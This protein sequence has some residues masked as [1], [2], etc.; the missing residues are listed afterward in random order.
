MADPYT[1]RFGGWL[2][3]LQNNGVEVPPQDNDIELPAADCLNVYW[4]DS[5]YRCLPS[6][7]SI[8]PSL[9]TPIL[10]CFTWYD[11]TQGKEVLFATTANGLWTLVDG[12]WSSVSIETQEGVTGF[13][14]S[15]RL[16]SVKGLATS[17]SPASE[18]ASGSTTSHVFSAL[19]ARIGSGTATSYTWSFS[20]HAG[21]GT[22]SIASGQGTANA[23]PQVTGSTSGST[24]TATCLCTIVANGVSYG[25]SSSLSY[26]QNT[27][28]PLLHAYTSGSGTETVP[29]GYTNVVI[30]IKGGGAGT[31]TPDATDT[32][33]DGGG[34][35][36]YC[37]TS[38]AVTPGGTFNYQVGVAGGTN[39]HGNGVGGSASTVT[40]GSI[41]LTT[42]T[43]N[44]GQGAGA[45][46]VGGTATGGNQANVTGHNGVNGG[47]G[48]TSGSAGLHFDTGNAYGRGA[49]YN[50][51]DETGGFVSFYYTA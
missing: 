51:N 40:S 31:S 5:S 23:V 10:D 14:I 7:A 22:W 47:V 18:S 20:A 35:A 2:P 1:I 25:V 42:M 19:S 44:G 28:P 3:D 43:A 34:G 21:P 45:N 9:G 50:T 38:M 24:S 48:G 39:I 17:V 29:A 33:L 41:S 8:G 49:N 26:T 36:A 46:G 15:I 13:S 30:E 16:G 37:R 11:N 4:Q 6:L 27:P 12:V 32:Y